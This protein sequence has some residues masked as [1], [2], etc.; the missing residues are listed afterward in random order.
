M[1]AAPRTSGAPI[2]RWA[3]S[4]ATQQEARRETGI[5]DATYESV[6]RDAGDWSSMLGIAGGAAMMVTRPG[7]AFTAQLVGASMLVGAADTAVQAS[8]WLSGREDADFGSTV[9]AATGLLPGV[10]LVTV[11][12]LKG[13]IARNEVARLGLLGANLAVIGY[14]VAHRGR[15]IVDRTEDASGEL[16]FGAALSGVAMSLRHVR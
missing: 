2:D 11:G 4:Y 5:A 3:R 8:R 16:A 7:N 12:L 14:E 6:R 13:G 15:R 9:Y 1:D 10:S